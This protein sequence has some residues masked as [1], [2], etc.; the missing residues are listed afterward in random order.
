MA[1]APRNPLREQLRRDAFLRRVDE[2]KRRHPH[3]SY[4]TIGRALGITQRDP[5]RFI[6]KLRTGETTGREAIPKIVKETA[7][8]N[9][10]VVAYRWWYTALP[11]VTYWAR[12]NIRVP[13]ATRF[14][15]FRLA[16]DPRVISAVERDLRRKASMKLRERDGSVPNPDR[17]AYEFEIDGVYP[18]ISARAPVLIIEGRAGAA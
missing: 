17:G 13:G 14:D 8:R 6:R 12:V 3:K 1:R 15:V 4:A 18:E 2:E 5:A 7:N 11:D 9:R 16:N 10:F